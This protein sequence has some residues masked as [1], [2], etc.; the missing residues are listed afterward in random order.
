MAKIFLVF[1]S[2]NANAYIALVVM[3]KSDKYQDILFKTW[4]YLQLWRK[5]VHLN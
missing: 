3:I 5:N 1:Y 4:A 2:E